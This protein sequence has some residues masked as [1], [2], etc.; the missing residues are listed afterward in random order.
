[1]VQ[2]ISSRRSLA[3]DVALLD[4]HGLG[5]ARVHARDAR[6]EQH[7][8]A[9]VADARDQQQPAHPG[10]RARDQVPPGGVVAAPGADV[11]PVVH[12]RG[13]SG[14]TRPRTGPPRSSSAAGR[15]R[16]SS[17]IGYCTPP[18]QPQSQRASMRKPARRLERL[19]RWSS[20]PRGCRRRTRDSRRTGRDTIQPQW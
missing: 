10:E 12:A 4:L 8:V 5:I 20:P 19:A 15:T 14:G 7:A 13:R 1:M 9:P 3:D 2:G 6:A 16:G 18:P 11:H 17:G